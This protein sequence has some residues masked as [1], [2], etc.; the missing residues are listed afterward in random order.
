VLKLDELL[1]A[2]RIYIQSGKMSA[3]AYLERK[4]PLREEKLPMAK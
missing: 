3:A 1:E 4:L 2:A